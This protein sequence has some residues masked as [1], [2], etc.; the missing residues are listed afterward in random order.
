MKKL[1]IGFVLVAPLFLN[2]ELNNIQK[3]DAITKGFVLSQI[4]RSEGVKFDSTNINELCLNNMKKNPQITQD[5]S[6][7]Y[8][9]M[10]FDKC[11][12]SLNK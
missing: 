12:E 8:V 7:E 10:V 3:G 9:Q 11:V 6:E 1:M 4:V 5:K 2:A